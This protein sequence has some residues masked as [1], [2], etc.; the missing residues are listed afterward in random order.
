V[1]P[2]TPVPSADELVAVADGTV[3]AAEVATNVAVGAT[4][5]FGAH[6]AADAALVTTRDAHD[7]VVSELRSEGGYVPTE[8]ETDRLRTLVA[9]EGTTPEAA[10][11]CSP[12]WLTAEIDVR[13]DGRTAAFLVVEPVDRDDPLATLPGIPAVAIHERDGFG[14][15]LSLAADLGGSHAA[16]IHTTRQRRVKR[17]AERLRV[18]RLV[19]NQPGTATVGSPQNGFAVAPMLGGGADERSELAGGLTVDDFVETTAVSTDVEPLD[20]I[21]GRG[22]NETWR[23]P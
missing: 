6:P 18:G 10:H 15:A 11:G 9:R 5:D 12:R 21:D 22:V 23:G 13:P 20:P 8:R 17:A 16:A 1:E 4:Y 2:P 19:V 3:P 14:S 7:D